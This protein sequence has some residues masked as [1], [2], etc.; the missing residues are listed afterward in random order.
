MRFSQSYV[1]TTHSEFD[2]FMYCLNSIA[3]GTYLEILI[4]HKNIWYAVHIY[5]K[6][7]FLQRR[8]FEKEYLLAPKLFFEAKKQTDPNQIL[9]VRQSSCK[10]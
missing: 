6:H 9:F 8:T 7:I 3:S 10:R 4:F 1:K 5:I 2:V